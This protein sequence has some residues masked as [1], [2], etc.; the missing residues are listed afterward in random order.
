MDTEEE[1]PDF[2]GD[3]PIFSGYEL[4]KEYSTIKNIIAIEIIDNIKQ[5][6]NI[7]ICKL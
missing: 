3:A 1:Y 6:C 5:G 4:E 2:F 7:T